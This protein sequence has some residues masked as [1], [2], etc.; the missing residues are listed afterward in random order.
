MTD[1]DRGTFATL[2]LGL[3]ETYGEPVSAARMEIYF[4]ALADL[5]LDAIREAAT[6]HVRS[7]KFFPRPSELLE[8]VEGPAAERA[9]LA[10]MAMLSLVRRYGW[11]GIDGKGTPPPF[12]D[13]ATRAAA[14]TM[15][16]GW[17]ALCAKLPGEGPELLGA[18]KLFKSSYV[19]YDG[20]AKRGAVLPAGR[21]A[22]RLEARD[23]LVGLKSELQK[24]GLPT[25]QL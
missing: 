6:A 16:G 14:M 20:Q 15:Y 19:A 5:E 21:E 17:G 11:P 24:R 7:S 3:G 10:W 22:G 4:A 13:E 25:G 2:M 9:E 12:P 1:Q 8:A 23:A 18:A